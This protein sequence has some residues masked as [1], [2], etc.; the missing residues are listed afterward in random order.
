MPTLDM[1]DFDQSLAGTGFK[2]PGEATRPAQASPYKFAVK[3][4]ASANKVEGTAADGR[5]HGRTG[6]SESNIS[7]RSSSSRPSV[8]SQISSAPLEV[9]RL[10]LLGSF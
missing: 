9:D 4:Q 7:S 2:A 6:S 1:A 8:S 10:R 5:S 3:E